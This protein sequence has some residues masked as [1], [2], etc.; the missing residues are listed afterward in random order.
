MWIRNNKLKLNP[1]KMKFIVIDDDQIRSSLESSFSVSFFGNIMEPAEL[2][3]NLGIILDADSSMQRHMANIC[4]ICYYHLRE[5]RRV[6]RYLNHKTA[7]K[8]A[9]ALASCPWITV[10]HCF[11]TQE[12][13]ILSDYKEF[14]MPYFVL[15]A[16]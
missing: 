14:K 16:I 4:L 10:T 12:R 15:C 13:H 11:I 7:V 6:H 2:V 1:D 8:V 9:N 3:N 5:L